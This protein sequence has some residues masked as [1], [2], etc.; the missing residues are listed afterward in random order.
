MK[1]WLIS[2]FLVFFVYSFIWFDAAAEVVMKVMTVNPSQ[3]KAQEASLKAYLPKEITPNHVLNLGDL[4]ISYDIEKDLYYVHKK[5]NL[6]PGESIT[7]EIRLEDVWVISQD[8]LDYII[9]Q[10]ENLVQSLEGTSY[11][12]QAVAAKKRVEAII[13]EIIEKQE[14]AKNASPDIH[15]AVYRKNHQ[16]LNEIKED[17][18]PRLEKEYAKAS[19]DGDGFSAK[20]FLVKTSWWII[21]GVISFLGIVSFILFIVWQ[22]QAKGKEERRRE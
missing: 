2:I 13:D 11:A 16:R 15:I 17:I 5:L 22:K 14:E 10:I 6:E 19:S 4:K 3:E 7:K 8:E 1:K 21:L 20:K 9:E 18:L 12:N